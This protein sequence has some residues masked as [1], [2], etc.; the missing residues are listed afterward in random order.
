MHQWVCL[1]MQR[2][3][4]CKNIFVPTLHF[5][6]PTGHE[7]KL[8]LDKQPVTPLVVYSPIVSY[9]ACFAVTLVIPKLFVGLMTPFK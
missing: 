7:Y 8:A 9:C 3:L 5:P 4:A 6:S 1:I 2:L